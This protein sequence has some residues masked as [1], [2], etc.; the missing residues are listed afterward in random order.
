MAV[1]KEYTTKI[2]MAILDIEETEAENKNSLNYFHEKNSM[3]IQ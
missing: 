1:K 3:A 2:G